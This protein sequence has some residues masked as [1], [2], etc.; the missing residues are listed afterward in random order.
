MVLK[1]LYRVKSIE[2]AATTVGLELMRCLSDRYPDYY[3]A[4]KKIESGESPLVMA[5]IATSSDL[6][7]ATSC[8]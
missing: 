6:L 2:L 3:S 5:S 1:F 8:R 7:L 4:E